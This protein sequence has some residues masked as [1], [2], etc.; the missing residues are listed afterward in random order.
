MPRVFVIHNHVRYDSERGQLVPRFDI[1]P[2]R[3]YGELI[4]VLPPQT[5]L[6]DSEGDIC[7]LQKALRDFNDED[8]LLLIGHPCFIGWATAIA[9]S[10]NEGRVR[11][12]AW[13][14][15]H[16]LSFSATLPVRAAKVSS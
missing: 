13:T 11:M 12:L 10:K 15:N 4:E 6:K 8:Y 1:S 16:Y 3:E 14:S 2:A 5:T 9:A 7:A